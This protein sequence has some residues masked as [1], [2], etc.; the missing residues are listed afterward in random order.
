MSKRALK[1][2]VAYAEGRNTVEAFENQEAAREHAQTETQH[3][4]Q[5][6]EVY[7]RVG[8]VTRVVTPRWL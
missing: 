4:G 8:I 5:T 2:L 1:Y 6:R 3:D 7:E